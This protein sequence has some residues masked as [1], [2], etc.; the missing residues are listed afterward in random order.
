MRGAVRRSIS[1]V[2]T[3]IFFNGRT[4]CPRR[5][6]RASRREGRSANAFVRLSASRRGRGRGYVSRPATKSVDSSFSGQPCSRRDNPVPSPFSFDVAG[7]ARTG[8][9]NRFRTDYRPNVPQKAKEEWGFR[10]R[11]IFRFAGRKPV[12]PRLSLCRLSLCLGGA[13]L[14]YAV[15]TR[16]GCRRTRKRRPCPYIGG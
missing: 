7:A 10:F 16:K 6:G 12:P 2:N 13:G 5:G 1:S 4:D 11:C 14:R 8:G 3:R 15:R 9:E